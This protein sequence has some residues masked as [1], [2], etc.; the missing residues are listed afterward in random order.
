MHNFNN[1]F[2]NWR[3]RFM[4]KSEERKLL[5]TLHRLIIQRVCVCV[6]VTYLKTTA[7]SWIIHSLKINSWTFHRYHLRINI[8]FTCRHVL[9]GFKELISKITRLWL[10]CYLL[11]SPVCFYHFLACF[12]WPSLWTGS[13]TLTALHLLN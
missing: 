1:F 13:V 7:V 8:H 9:D 2:F 10:G 11:F 3:A 12:L 5:I 4:A 6:C